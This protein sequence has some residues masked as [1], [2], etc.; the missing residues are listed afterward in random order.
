MGTNFEFT[1]EDKQRF[2]DDPEEFL[3][4]RKVVEASINSVFRL[5]LSGSEENRFLFKLVDSV[6]R[7]RLSKDPELADKLIPKYEIGCRRLS[8]GD[9]YL[10]ALQADNAEIRFDSIQRITETGIQTDKGIEEFDLIV[11]A[12]GFNASFIPAWDLVGRDGRR[13]DEEWKEKPEAY[14]SVCA[15]GIPNYF[16]SV[17]VKDSVVSDYNIYAQENLKRAVWSKGCHAW[18]SKKT[19]GE[20]VTV[21]AMYP[22][23]VL[24]YKAV[25]RTIRGEHFDIRYN[26]TNPFRY[27][28]NGELAFEREKGADLAFYLK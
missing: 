14:F 27:L 1:K 7:A 22:G 2:R 24:H 19:T 25:L 11:C 9:G 23:S 16:I 8:P 17:V 6:M 5:M 18:Y 26:T 12:T 15:A 21:T 3:K 28:G 10:E 20:G 4:Y 13:L